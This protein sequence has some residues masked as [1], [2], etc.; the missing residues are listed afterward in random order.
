VTRHEFTLTPA[1]KAC[2]LV[3]HSGGQ[4]HLIM[5]IAHSTALH[6]GVLRPKWDLYVTSFPMDLQDHCERGVCWGGGGRDEEPE[7]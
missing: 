3:R 5:A 2:L 7:E 1:Y 4:R 6:S